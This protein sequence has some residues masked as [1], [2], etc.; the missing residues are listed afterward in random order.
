[1]KILLA[2]DNEKNRRLLEMTLKQKYELLICKDGEEALKAY[3]AEK[4][5]LVILD[6]LMPKMDGFTVCRRMREHGLEK[7]I[8]IIISSAFYKDD[9]YRNESEQLGADEF[10]PKPIKP[11]DLLQTVERLLRE[12]R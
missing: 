8:P 6:A 2:D 4:P 12:V 1:M 11:A 7:R 3:I 10:L 9:V 5:D